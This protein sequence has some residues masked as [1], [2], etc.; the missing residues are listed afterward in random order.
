M[1]ER[2]MG[3][4]L[5][6][7]IGVAIGTALENLAI[8]IAVGVAI[9]AAFEAQNTRERETAEEK[10]ATDNPLNDARSAEKEAHL[11]QVLAYAKSHDAVTNEEVQHLVGVSAATAERYLD[12]LEKD[13][14]L[15]QIGATGKSV[16]YKIV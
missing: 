15:S 1:K 3:M 6:I 11:A 2:G 4:A 13:G 5:G 12:E 9:G 10:S 7:V 16:S 14:K 8:G